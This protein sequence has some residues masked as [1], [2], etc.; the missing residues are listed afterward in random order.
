MFFPVRPIALLQSDLHGLYIASF[1]VRRTADSAL[2]CPVLQTSESPMTEATI[3]SPNCST[4]V[5]LTES[6]V[7]ILHAE[8]SGRLGQARDVVG[9]C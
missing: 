4:A 5:P 9:A 8:F 1:G 6:P 2:S 3:T 7:I